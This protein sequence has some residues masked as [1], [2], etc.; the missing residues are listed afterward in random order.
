MGRLEWNARL[1]EGSLGTDDSL[2]DG[3]LRDKE[4][5]GDLLSR[6]TSEQTERERN[7]CVGRKYRMAGHEHE[8]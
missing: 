6:Q 8:A 3:R 4:G 2:G 1:S 5:A 7:T